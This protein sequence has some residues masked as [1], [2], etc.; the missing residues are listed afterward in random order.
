M[1][2]QDSAPNVKTTDGHAGRTQALPDDRVLVTLD[3]GRS[4][5]VDATQLEP[6]DD[7][8]YLVTVTAA[9]RSTLTGR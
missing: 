3:D 4:F 8:T 2:H 7:G 5:V 1:P 9:D 6:Q